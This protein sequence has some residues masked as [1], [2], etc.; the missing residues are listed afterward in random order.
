MTQPMKSHDTSRAQ[1]IPIDV[2]LITALQPPPLSLIKEPDSLFRGLPVVLLG[3]AP[4]RS[5]FS[6]ISR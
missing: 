6:V 5:Q 1:F 3:L 2:L 4:A